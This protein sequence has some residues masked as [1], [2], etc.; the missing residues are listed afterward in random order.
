VTLVLYPVM[1]TQASAKATQAGG[2]TIK[3]FT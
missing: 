2:I 1:P 3:M